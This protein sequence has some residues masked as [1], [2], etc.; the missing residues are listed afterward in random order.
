MIKLCLT[1]ALLGVVA[2][3]AAHAQAPSPARNSLIDADKSVAT[4]IFQQGIRAGL[5]P[6]LSDDVVFL[7]EG[8]PL[9][10]GRGRVLQ[11]LGSHPHLARLRVQRMRVF[12]ALSQDGNYGTTTGASIISRQ[13]QPPDSAAGFGHYIAVWRRDSDTAPWRIVAL[14]EN[15]LMGD[16]TFQR[17]AG[18]E[19][20]P[21]PLLAGTARQMADADLAFAKMA[22][23][24]NVGAAFGNYASPDATTPPGESDMIV[25]AAAIRTRMST[26]ARMQQVW[27]WHPVYA[28]ATAAG[29]FGFTAG[30]AT[31]RASR[32][33]T[34]GYEGKYL[35]VWQRQTDGTLKFVLDSGNSR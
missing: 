10:A 7:F 31:I 21:V 1:S 3:T 28:G 13:G 16:E 27:L 5:E 9:L 20:G 17:P 11:V 12:V 34:E 24:S 26:P 18:F 19:T 25:G 4:A 33:A 14:V 30:E 29:D 15:G 6:H 22:T 32:T 35:T 8:A 23:D 2:F